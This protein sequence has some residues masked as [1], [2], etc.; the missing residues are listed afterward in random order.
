MGNTRHRCR[1]AT[2][3]MKNKPVLFFL[4]RA[5]IIAR[6]PLPAEKKIAGALARLGAS[7]L[8]GKL[9]AATGLCSRAGAAS[10]RIYAGCA[11][12]DISLQLDI[13]AS[14]S[15]VCVCKTA[16]WSASVRIGYQRGRVGYA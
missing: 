11:S 16:S 9:A 8:P 15:R 13:S 1:R 12:D 3:A 5:R 4:R 2:V 7:A 10:R 6:G 14:C